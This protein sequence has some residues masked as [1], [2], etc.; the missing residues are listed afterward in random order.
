MQ[1][2]L[3]NKLLVIVGP[4]AVG[5]TEIALKLAQKLAG[6]IVSSDSKQFYKH[7]SIGT[8]KPSI[9]ER[10]RVPHHLVDFCEPDHRLSLAEFQDM[11]YAAISNI[12]ARGKLPILVGGTGQYVRAVLEGWG[13]PEVEPHHGLRIDL[14]S[15]ADTYGPSALHT[16]LRQVDP[17]AADNIDFRNVRRV[18]RALEVYLVAGAPISRL[19]QANP[20]P[21]DVLQIGLTRDKSVL[22]QRVSY[23]VD[24]MVEQGLVA[25][26]EALL[27]MG[28]T[29]NLP[30]MQSLGY[31]QLQPFFEGQVGLESAIEE[32][33][34]ATLDFVRRQY[35]WFRLD[36]AA[37]TWFD[38]D[39]VSTSEVL[40]VVTNWAQG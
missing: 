34:R 22:E 21:Y 29:W 37:I 39:L 31:I 36:D 28:L 14:D 4:T 18:V 8:A 10:A 24:T 9:S 16:W 2:R 7:L 11:A 3:T 13:I 27:R 38:L 19:Q 25:E 23:R 40:S 26:V 17:T 15:F 6:E 20:P 32:T 12:Q 1:S 35:T 5:K 33:K 30:A